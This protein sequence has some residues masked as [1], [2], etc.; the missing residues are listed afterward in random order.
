ML[1]GIELFCSKAYLHELGREQPEV[2]FSFRVS[3]V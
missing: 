3:W 2:S 1:A